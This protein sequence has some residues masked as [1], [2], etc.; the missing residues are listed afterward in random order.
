GFQVSIRSQ[1]QRMNSVAPSSV[2]SLAQRVT[3][4]PR[5][6]APHAAQARVED[7]LPGTAG[8]PAGKTLTRLITIHPM[9]DGLMMGLAEASPYLWELARAE[10]ERLPGPPP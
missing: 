4:A 7:C 2:G 1:V 6:T 9:L 5:L 3:A 10:P 8:P